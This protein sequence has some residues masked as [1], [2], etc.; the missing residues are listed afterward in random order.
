MDRAYRLYVLEGGVPQVICETSM[1]G[2]GLALS[3]MV[4]EGEITEGDRVGVLY[5]PNEERPGIWLINPFGKGR[6]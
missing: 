5:R 6:P 2:L 3:T 1:D 4:A